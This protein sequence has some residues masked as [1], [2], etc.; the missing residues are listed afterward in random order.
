MAIMELKVGTKGEIYTT[1][2][3]RRAVGIEP[4]GVVVAQVEEKQLIL[5]PKVRGEQLLEKPRLSV[6]PVSGKEMS[7]LRRKLA[8]ELAER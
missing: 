2:E 4:R 1:D 3:V 5:R 7:M 6:P 8:T